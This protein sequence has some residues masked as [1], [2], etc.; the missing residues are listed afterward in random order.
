MVTHKKILFP[1]SVIEE[2]VSSLARRINEDYRGQSLVTVGILK[3]SFVFM[4]DLVRKLDLDVTVDFVALA[5]YGS[6]TTTSGEVK[7][8]KDLAAPIEGRHVLVVE[9]IVDTGITLKYLADLL[10]RRRPK[11]LAICALIDKKARREV[12][13]DVAYVGLEMED[14]FIVGYGIDCNEQYRN[15]P[16][17]WVIEQE[18]DKE[19]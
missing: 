15:L 12:E 2:A 9:D 8:L 4:A 13:I 3:G 16:E 5:S 14:G 1:K 11:S 18:A 10:E 17:I 6:G 19:K 7:M